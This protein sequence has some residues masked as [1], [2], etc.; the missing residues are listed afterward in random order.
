MSGRVVGTGDTV[1]NRTG[2]WAP[3]SHLHSD[4]RRQI[5]KCVA[6]LLVMITLEINKE[7][8]GRVGEAGL[9]F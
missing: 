3:E 6:G 2:L 8:N 4:V 1:R 9:L 7:V 5:S